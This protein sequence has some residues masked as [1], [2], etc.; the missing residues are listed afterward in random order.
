MSEIPEPLLGACGDDCSC[1]P[2]YLAT[3]SDD[4]AALCRVKDLWVSL[5]WRSPNVDVQSLRCPGCRKENK[6]ACPELRDCAFDRGLK[7]CGE[8]DEYPCGHTESAF[9]K[10]EN[11]LQSLNPDTCTPEEMALLM[12]AFGFKKSNLDDVHRDRLR[13]ASS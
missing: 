8:C 4:S 3:V 6:C 13:A 5:G 9:Q 2:R 12:N 11:T 10:T 7:N 1:C